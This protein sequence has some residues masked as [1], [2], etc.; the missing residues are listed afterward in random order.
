[1][2]PRSEAEPHRRRRRDRSRTIRATRP[3]TCPT[4][5]RRHAAVASS[6]RSWDPTQTSSHH[7]PPLDESEWSSI[8]RTASSGCFRGRG[9][10]A[11]ATE[12]P[13]ARPPGLRVASSRHAVTYGQTARGHPVDRLRPSDDVSPLDG[14]QLDPFRRK[15]SCG[16]FRYRR[17]SRTSP[18]GASASDRGRRMASSGRFGCVGTGRGHSIAPR[19]RCRTGWCCLPDDVGGHP[20]TRTQTRALPSHCPPRSGGPG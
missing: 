7:Y 3:L 13:T 15:A 18:L 19:G 12:S 5:V 4:G 8:R 9:P 6:R 16:C 14:P 20:P 17:W 2:A 1:M 10:S 11:A